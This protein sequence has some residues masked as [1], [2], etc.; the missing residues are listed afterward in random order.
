MMFV[1]F[2]K[3]SFHL[4]FLFIDLIYISIPMLLFKYDLYLFQEFNS[5]QFSMNVY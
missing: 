2:W 3:Y 5:F 4:I 1:K